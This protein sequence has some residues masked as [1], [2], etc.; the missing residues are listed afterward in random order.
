MLTMSMK[1]SKL[2]KFENELKVKSK[3]HDNEDLFDM[4]ANLFDYQLI[5]LDQT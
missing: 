4:D 5:K 3:N 1:L 2:D